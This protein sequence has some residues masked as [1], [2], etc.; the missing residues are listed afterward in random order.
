M[1]VLQSERISRVYIL[2]V[3]IGHPYA[4][5]AC[6]HLQSDWA[7]EICGLT[8]IAP[9]VSTLCPHSWVMA[10]FGARV[11]SAI[12]YGSTEIISSVSAW[13]LPSFLRPPA[14]KNLV[15]PEEQELGGWTENDFEDAYETV[16]ESV[17]MTKDATAIEARVGTSKIWQ[18]EVCDKFAVENGFGLNLGEPN[19]KDVD[20]SRP[21][22]L[23]A[24]ATSKK[25]I[26]IRIYACNEDKLVPL[27]AV[28]WIAKRCYGNVPIDVE[29]CIHSHELMTFFGG[30]PRA[31][32]LLHKIT[33]AWDL[34]DIS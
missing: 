18:T 1:E 32:I 28:K 17:A 11:P 21:I 31:P 30:P 12:F 33:R 27:E 4:I 6:R 2:G 14:F 26:P 25:R 3:C 9:F 19:E 5:E 7:I 29:E 13:A 10:R 20:A 24:G 15:T 22:T 8:L 23:V 16:L 34:L